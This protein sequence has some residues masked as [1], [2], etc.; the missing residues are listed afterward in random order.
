MHT[1]TWNK[2][3]GNLR[4][5]VDNQLTG[6]ATYTSSIDI[7]DGDLYV[8]SNTHSIYVGEGYVYNNELSSTDVSTLF[9]NTKGRYGL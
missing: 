1:V 8:N 3:T 4:H 7:T 2:S 9:N 6:S 5:Y